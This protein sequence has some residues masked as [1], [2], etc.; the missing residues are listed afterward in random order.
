[1]DSTE[2]S[3]PSQQETNFS[4]APTECS[5]AQKHELGQ[6]MSL[7]KCKEIEIVQGIFSNHSGVKLEITNKRKI[8]KSTSLSKLNNTLLKKNY[9]EN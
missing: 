2:L 6:E 9:K 1:M 8:G 4:Q 5:L 7:S 3:T